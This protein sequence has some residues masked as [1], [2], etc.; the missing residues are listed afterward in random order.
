MDGTGDITGKRS[1]TID[2]RLSLAND[3]AC[4]YH[5]GRVSRQVRMNIQVKGQQS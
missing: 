4:G 1:D 2:I 3:D 5:I